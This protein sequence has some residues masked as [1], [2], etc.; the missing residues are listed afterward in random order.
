MSARYFGGPA[1]DMCIKFRVWDDLRHICS[2]VAVIKV[3][4]GELTTLLSM[5]FDWLNRRHTR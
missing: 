3:V 1:W 4:L 2:L 5:L